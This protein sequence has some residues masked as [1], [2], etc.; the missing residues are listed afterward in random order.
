[1]KGGEKVD[2][3][4]LIMG[5]VAP[6]ICFIVMAMMCVIV[7]GTPIA[8]YKKIVGGN[9]AAKRYLAKVYL[10]EVK[11]I[12]KYCKVFNIIWLIFC[13]IQCIVIQVANAILS[14]MI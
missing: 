4:L 7:L 5:F 6:W 2:W 14:S 13:I 12:K 10:K 1:M 8:I 11:T 3:K 9:K